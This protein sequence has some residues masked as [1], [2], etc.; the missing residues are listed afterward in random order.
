MHSTR[1][2]KIK[3][4]TLAALQANKQQIL[5]QS[6]TMSVPRNLQAVNHT[7]HEAYDAYLRSAQVQYDELV[8]EG[9]L[10]PAESA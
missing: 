6:L 1:V 9:T 2:L 5:T 4:R 8:K 7:E 3:A 10:S